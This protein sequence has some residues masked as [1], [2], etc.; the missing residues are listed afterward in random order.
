MNI[1]PA[2]VCI[3]LN[4]QLNKLMQSVGKNMNEKIAA[5]MH[6]HSRVNEAD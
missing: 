3:S 4:M 1:P 6:F 2:Q 5:S